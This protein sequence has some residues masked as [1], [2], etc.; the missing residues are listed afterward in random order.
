MKL[1]YIKKNIMN[2][3]VL[4]SLLFSKGVTTFKSSFFTGLIV[5]LPTGI[6]VFIAW[7]LFDFLGALI[8]YMYGQNMPWWLGSMV[9]ATV[10]F[11][12]GLMVRNFVG[13]RLVEYIEKLFT[14]LPFI[15]S[16]YSTIKQLIDLAIANKNMVFKKVVAFEY[17]RKGIYTIGFISASGP[18][19][20]KVKS[21]KN[22]VTVFVSTTPNPTSGFLL[23]VPEEE[24]IYLD[25]TAEDGMKLIISGGII[26]PEYTIKDFKAELALEK[27][28]S[29]K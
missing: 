29:L 2:I 17:P 3:W 6:T 23:F 22:L 8:K 24:I 19:E 15:R 11:A 21:S 18:D 26:A 14:K 25:M 4:L 27:D 7:K 28:T 20:L 13:R 10:I 12:S 5:L 16:L 1:S 9:T